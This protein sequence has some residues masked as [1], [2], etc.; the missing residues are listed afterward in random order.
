MLIRRGAA[1]LLDILPATIFGTLFL[2]FFTDL[3]ELYTTYLANKNDPAIHEKY[4]DFRLTARAVVTSLC[5]VYCVIF[6]CF[7]TFNTP[8]KKLLGIR[9]VSE[10]G[11]N[12]TLVQSTLRNLQKFFSP[13]YLLV[14]IVYS[15]F[16]RQQLFLHDKWSSTR[17][18][19]ITD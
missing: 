15:L 16:N 7:Y 5:V 9:V 18:V 13:F 4:D 6:E 3:S 14:S 17:V 8:G 10:D 12:L 2:W 11:D 1:Y 19:R